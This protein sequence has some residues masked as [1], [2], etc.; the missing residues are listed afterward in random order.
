MCQVC[1]VV[2]NIIHML[3]N[4]FIPVVI[5]NVKVLIFAPRVSSII[6]FQVKVN[7]CVFY[8]MHSLYAT[9]PSLCFT[10]SSDTLGLCE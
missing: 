2:M 5:F 9:F 1:A 3:H 10:S 8:L 4:T 7:V 6:L